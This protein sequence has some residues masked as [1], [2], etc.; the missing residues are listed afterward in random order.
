MTVLGRDYVM[1]KDYSDK[2]GIIAIKLFIL[3][4]FP[5]ALFAMAAPAFGATAE[6]TGK[7][8]TDKASDGRNWRRGLAPGKND[9]VLFDAFSSKDCSWDLNITLS[10]VL[11]T[12]RYKGSV[13][14]KTSGLKVAG[15]VDIKGGMLNLRKGSLIVGRRIYVGSSGTLELADG[16]LSVGPM[17]VLVDNGGT[18]LSMGRSK[19]KIMSAKPGKYYKFIVGQ[20]NVLLSNPAGTEVGG[21]QGII[22]YS[23]AKVNQADFVNVK[24]LKPGT[25]AV[26]V[27]VAKGQKNGQ[28]LAF[29]GWTFDKTVKKKGTRYA[30]FKEPE[31]AALALDARTPEDAIEEPKAESEPA[32]FVAAS[33]QPALS[34]KSDRYK[35]VAAPFTAL[36][37]VPL[38]E[39]TAAVEP[40][41]TPF[42]GLE[43]YE[44]AIARANFQPYLAV[45]FNRGQ[46]FF[47]REQGN[48]SGNLNVLASMAIKHEKLGPKLTL[49][50]VVS[51]QYQGTKQ[52]TDL[53][54][55]GTLFQ[56][57]MAHSLALRGIYQLSP[58][59]KLKPAVGY[60]WEFL[61]ETRD[62]SW[63][64]GLFDYR[65][66]SFSLEGEYAYRDPFTFSIGY[67][68][69][70]IGFMN[71][72]S[73]ESII[74]DSQGNAMARELAGRSV[75][76][77][78]NHS[79]TFGG[80]AQGPWRSYAE[81]NLVTTLRLFPEQHVVSGT[82]DYKNS[83]RRDLSN[84]LSAA[85]KI[86]REI[87]GSWKAVGGARL[88]AGFNISNQNSY[89][90]QRFKYLKN[91]YDSTS[92]R[93]GVDLNLYRKMP[94]GR[95][96]G[97]EERP[98]EFSL[99]ATLG[100]I[101]YGGRLAQAAS[102]LYRG[103]RIYQNEA[104]LGV[105]VSYPIAPHFTWTS[106]FG[107]GRQTSNQ[108][109]ER[110]YKYNFTTTNYRIG[111]SYEY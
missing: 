52:V 20:G 33:A 109:F 3:F 15:N 67:D 44:D 94:A 79:L 76:D 26:R 102:G 108:D 64:N 19:A 83:T 78:Y 11:M 28:K 39:A 99:S 88:A 96:G 61:K 12:A 59:W 74:K 71:Y 68:F 27:F 75:L 49:V 89:D 30:E 87:W 70:H 41:E 32:T 14:L 62:E 69:Y 73:L 35:D 111:F 18:L 56:E 13:R 107:Y 82:G 21:S 55:G 60:K 7:G 81:G 84:Q 50:P 53:V 42:A 17:G 93:A 31:P 57:R 90:A 105:G 95:S 16:A 48:L 38:A 91:Y 40:E 80:T 34:D 36:T 10:S 100:R 47:Q 86:P 2:K 65:R 5:F 72:S 85:L 104:V 54:G 46:H 24:Q 37:P 92:I 58:K 106:Q 4:A 9:R 101:S 1:K 45:Q 6:W 43:E 63:G 25:A 8:R 66:P 98:L 22:L 77:S 97:T 23:K 51:S 29:K 103:A 110:L